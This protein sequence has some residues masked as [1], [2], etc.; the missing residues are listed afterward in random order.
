MT[1]EMLRRIDDERMKD[2]K[3]RMAVQD[4]LLFEIRDR[5]VAQGEHLKIQGQA[6][7]ALNASLDEHKEALTQH[8]AEENKIAPALDELV[9][10]WKG[11]KVLI[12][13]IGTL[14]AAI[15]WAISWLKDHHIFR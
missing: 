14:G 9:S 8:I 13:L 3:E 4:Q 1:E 2:F 12:P 7:T 6:L 5:T 10:L 15:G 11:S